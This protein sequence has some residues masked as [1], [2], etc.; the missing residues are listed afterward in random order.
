MFCKYTSKIFYGIQIICI[1][2]SHLK[3]QL[4]TKDCYEFLECK[5]LWK[6]SVDQFAGLPTT[7]GNASTENGDYPRD[8]TKQRSVVTLQFCISE[9]YKIPPLFLLLPKNTRIVD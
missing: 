9:E 4:F 6:L 8:D 3:L 1:K 5:K 2:K 7:A